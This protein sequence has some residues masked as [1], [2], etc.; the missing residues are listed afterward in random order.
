MDHPTTKLE[1][2]M[3]RVS[4]AMRREPQTLV[5]DLTI[6]VAR[7][8]KLNPLTLRAYIAAHMT[9]FVRSTQK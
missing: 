7:A 3:L 9:A 4:L 5:E 2:A 1:V 6:T 8:M